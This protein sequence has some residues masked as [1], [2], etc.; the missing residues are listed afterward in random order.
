[1]SSNCPPQLHLTL[2]ANATSF[3]RSFEQFGVDLEESPITNIAEPGGSGAGNRA[4]GSADSGNTRTGNERKR[5]RSASSLSDGND[6][7]NSSR[8]STFTASS[9][10]SLSEDNEPIAE[11]SG[12]S[13][14][15]LVSAITPFVDPHPPRLPTPDIQDIEMPDYGQ[16]AVVDPNTE[17]APS[18]NDHRH[19]IEEPHT[20]DPAIDVQRLPRSSSPNS[21][22]YL[23][24]PPTL[25]PL[26]LSGEEQE[27]LPLLHSR[28]TSNESSQR[29]S[30][31]STTSSPHLQDLLVHE[32][33]PPPRLPSPIYSSSPTLSTSIP[34][35]DPSFN[36]DNVDAVDEASPVD[37]GRYVSFRDRLN[38]AVGLLEADDVSE[39][40]ER[41]TS[42]LDA[43]RTDGTQNQTDAERIISHGVSP[44]HDRALGEQASSRP[45][46]SLNSNNTREAEAY[47]SSRARGF[48]S[49]SAD[50]RT[51]S[52]LRPLYLASQS[53]LLRPREPFPRSQSPSAEINDDD[54]ISERTRP[55]RASASSTLNPL[56][57]LSSHLSTSTTATLRRS[58]APQTSSSRPPVSSTPTPLNPSLARWF[59]DPADTALES[60]PSPFSVPRSEEHLPGADDDWATVVGR[61]LGSRRHARD[62]LSDWTLPFLRNSAS[63]DHND[64][65]QDQED[66]DLVAGLLSSTHNRIDNDSTNTALENS[67]SARVPPS[68]ASL[69]SREYMFSDSTNDDATSHYPDSSD[70]DRERD[71]VSRRFPDVSLFPESFRSQLLSDAQIRRYTRSNVYGSRDNSASA[72][73][74]RQDRESTGRSDRSEQPTGSG[75]RLTGSYF[76]LLGTSRT[77]C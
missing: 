71:P 77:S 69:V 24:P 72:R 58:Q 65:D 60:V 68:L 49:S 11:S 41:L 59:E 10:T 56:H 17:T 35:V 55:P 5:A 45:W 22:R 50:V 66:E 29:L 51:E 21:R 1:M 7:L 40:R 57:R 61:Q 43:V 6:S 28:S 38:T 8:S 15:R 53:A 2:P 27:Q 63:S 67:R 32:L 39:F 31:T 12:S 73:E 34:V 52:R 54:T 46:R 75:Y 30:F 70:S 47:S 74:Q 20:P 9:D 16:E 25:P 13:M 26:T 42:A 14:S 48:F 76:E 19:Y 36:V 3:K 23:T 62:T 64:V 44:D 33:D 4:S 37:V 18:S